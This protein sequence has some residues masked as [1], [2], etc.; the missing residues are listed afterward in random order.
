MSTP[1]RSRLLVQALSASWLLLPLAL[2]W[3]LALCVW[4]GRSGPR[5]QWW[6]DSPNDLGPLAAG[7]AAACWVF[8]R[9]WATPPPNQSMRWSRW[10]GVA[11]CIVAS[12]VW[13]AGAVGSA[14]RAGMLV[15]VAAAILLWYAAPPGHRRWALAWMICVGAA[16]LLEPASAARAWTMAPAQAAAD[17]SIQHRWEIWSSAGIMLTD[18][19]RVPTGLTFLDVYTRWYESRPRGAD[20]WHPLNDTL[21][22]VADHGWAWGAAYAATLGG[23]LIGVLGAAVHQR[24]AWALVAAIGML[25]VTIGG[26]TSSLL[27]EAGATWWVVGVSV[28]AA[29]VL[30]CQHRTRITALMVGSG[31]VAG[32]VAVLLTYAVASHRAAAYPVRADPADPLCTVLPRTGAAKRRLT[33]LISERSDVTAYGRELARPL[34][35]RG[36]SVHLQLA[37]EPLQAG[38]VLLVTRGVMS[39]PDGWQSTHPAGLVLIDPLPVC[40]RSTPPPAHGLLVT[41]RQPVSTDG[42]ACADHDVQRIW[43]KGV[44]ACL[45]SLTKWLD[46][47]GPTP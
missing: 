25:A 13:L 3:I 20:V 26:G 18:L 21:L 1:A 34:A 39:L 14:S 4:V 6:F 17:Q 12:G 16:Y 11:C 38:D 31:A 27:R 30:V 28:G 43:A 42:W 10:I 23:L 33:V 36:F 40:L 37:D 9:T 2:G 5:W 44:A 22:M 29:G 47:P 35:A 46:E 32:L 24:S 45:P 41:A 8:A 19:P 15:A 7:C